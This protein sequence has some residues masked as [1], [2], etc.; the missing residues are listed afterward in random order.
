[1]TQLCQRQICFAIASVPP[2]HG[3]VRMDFRAGTPVVNSSI[4][5]A[6]HKQEKN[7]HVLRCRPVSVLCM[8][9]LY[10]TRWL[11]LVGRFSNAAHI[12]MDNSL[13]LC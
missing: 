8:D 4:N 9:K 13:V 6:G 2:S 5:H 12:C 3:A 11:H 10:I 7:D 1:M